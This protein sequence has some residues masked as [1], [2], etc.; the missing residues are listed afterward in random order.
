MTDEYP[1][2]YTKYDDMA[3]KAFARLYWELDND[4]Q[5]EVRDLHDDKNT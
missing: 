4:Q 5:I 3:L 2:G 1:E